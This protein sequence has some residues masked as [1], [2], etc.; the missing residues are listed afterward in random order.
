MESRW[1]LTTIF[2]FMVSNEAG[3][4]GMC[5]KRKSRFCGHLTRACGHVRLLGSANQMGFIS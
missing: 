5:A 4:G 3:V 2:I 1:K